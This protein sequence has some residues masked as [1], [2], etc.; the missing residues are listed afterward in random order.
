MTSTPGQPSK[1]PYSQPSEPSYLPGPPLP[2]GGHPYHFQNQLVHRPL[3][4]IPEASEHG[5]PAEPPEIPRR[6][7]SPARQ[8]L[9]RKSFAGQP[10]KAPEGKGLFAKQGGSVPRNYSRKNKPP[11]LYLNHRHPLI[12]DH[13]EQERAERERLRLPA[14]TPRS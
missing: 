13:E 10:K 9:L 6:F 2:Q 5:P 3:H 12:S 11:P 14:V 8:N 4:V 7:G 1:Q